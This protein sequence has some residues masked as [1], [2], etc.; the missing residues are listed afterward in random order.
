MSTKQEKIVQIHVERFEVLD[1]KKSYL[2]SVQIKTQSFDIISQLVRHG[3]ILEATH[4]QHIQCLQEIGF[5]F[6]LLLDV[7][8]ENS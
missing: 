5:G 2:H 4:R 6:F 7:E 1:A 8:V 3:V